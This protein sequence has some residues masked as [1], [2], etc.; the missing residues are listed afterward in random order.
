MATVPAEND[1]SCPLLSSVL[2]RNCTEKG[3]LSNESENDVEAS[4]THK[5]KDFQLIHV[6]KEAVSVE[7][8]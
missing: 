5:A 6:P 1:E 2:D 8:L 7:G 4:D 3:Q